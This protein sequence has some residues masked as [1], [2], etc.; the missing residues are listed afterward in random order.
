MVV[1]NSYG[2]ATGK[3]AYPEAQTELIA[4]LTEKVNCVRFASDL[5]SIIPETCSAVVFC[6]TEEEYLEAVEE[7]CTEMEMVL[8][9]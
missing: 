5:D 6:D 3:N 9:E 8:V 4:R 1:G 2:V 7:I